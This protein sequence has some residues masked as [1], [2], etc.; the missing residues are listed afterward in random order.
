LNVRPLA[1]LRARAASV[2]RDLRSR[3]RSA[4]Q[5]MDFTHLDFETPDEAARLAGGALVRKP[6]AY[7]R[8]RRGLL[9]DVRR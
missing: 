1:A 6:A 2:A 8:L 4:L 7:G 5:A 3:S 9:V